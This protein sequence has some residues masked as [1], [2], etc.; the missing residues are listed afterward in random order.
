MRSIVS[1]ALPFR[2]AVID[3]VFSSLVRVGVGATS[4]RVLGSM[5]EVSSRRRRIVGERSN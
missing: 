5:H 2:R 4:I 3:A 1:H